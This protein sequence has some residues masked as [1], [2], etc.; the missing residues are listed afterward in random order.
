MYTR[1][2]Y[3]S[4][5]D[6]DANMILVEDFDYWQRIYMKFDC[7]VI[8]DILYDYRWHDGA[9]TSTMRKEQ[10]N[11]NLEKMLLKNISGFGKLDMLQK[12]Y[13]YQ[14]LYKCRENLGGQKNP[15]SFKRNLLHIWYFWTHRVPYGMKRR[16]KAVFCLSEK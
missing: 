4:I 2:A 5:G 14:G 7:A 6:Y 9:L 11:S 8:E 1:K 10:F 12:Y 15:Y 13:Y 3:E 16:M